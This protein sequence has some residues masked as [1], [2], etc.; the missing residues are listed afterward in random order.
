MKEWYGW[1]FPELSKVIPDN[2]LFVRVVKKMG[3]R[4][5]AKDT[6]FSDVL[7]EHMAQELKNTAEISMGTEVSDEDITNILELGSQILSISEY[8]EQ[9]FDYLK[10]RMNAIAPNLTVLVGEII[11][12][13]LISHAGSL[14]NLAKHPA[15]TIQI[16]GAEKAL[17]RALK[18]KHETPK[19]GI[20]YNASLV[21]QT[22][23]KNK[24]KISRVLA[25]KVALSCRVDALGEDSNATPTIGLENLQKV[26]TRKRQLE[27]HSMRAISGT[28]RSSAK[29]Q[30]YD[31]N[32][33]ASGS[34]RQSSAYRSDV[35]F[36]AKQKSAP[37]QKEQ[38]FE[39]A[40]EQVE[41]VEE[42]E[43]SK[44][45]KSSSKEKS[46][47]KAKKSKKSKKSKE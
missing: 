43:S 28:A 4:E 7:E 27:G 47:K 44:K 32:R 42:E 38:F 45:R 6:D 16:L 10:N 1:H 20:I 23:P 8:R 12:A 3:R 19:Y 36:T 11:G 40:E 31:K 18:T 34:I 22:A 21:G 26:E 41:Q 29:A 25:A 14:L 30:K 15:S 9:L 33:D 24:G 39:E 46:A 17:F 35:D 13:R 5:N 2:T 37:V